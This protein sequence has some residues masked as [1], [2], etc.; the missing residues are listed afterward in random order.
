M[1]DFDVGLVWFRRDLRAA[2]NAA[3]YHALTR[4]R[5]VLCAFVFDRE[6]LSP[7]ESK[8]LQR[9]AAI[10]TQVFTEKAISMKYRGIYKLVKRAPGKLTYRAAVRSESLQEI[11]R[12]WF[13]NHRKPSRAA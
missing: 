4:C 7:L 5:R 13:R 12:E 2:D 11:Y 9:Y 6:I 3:L 10:R 1:A 8:T